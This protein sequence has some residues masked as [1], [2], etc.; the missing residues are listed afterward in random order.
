MGSPE[1]VPRPPRPGTPG[2]LGDAGE[3]ACTNSGAMT[4]T[5]G[6]SAV[7]LPMLSK[8]EEIEY[9][10]PTLEDGQSRG[11]H[12]S[13]LGWNHRNRNSGR[14]RCSA[15]QPHSAMTAATA[16]SIVV[17]YKAQSAASRLCDT[18]RTGIASKP[19][20]LHKPTA[21]LTL[22]FRC[23]GVEQQKGR[24]RR[25]GPD[26]Q[27]SEW[28]GEDLNLRP[29]GYEPDELPDCSTPRRIRRSYMSGPMSAMAPRHHGRND[30]RLPEAKPQR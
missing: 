13:L 30:C 20:E 1:I 21:L 18:T 12:G 11:P 2:K 14:L 5:T 15:I 9:S 10:V 29:S 24:F 3:K 17:A 8:A 19:T 6:R 22:S 27:L 28:R 26:L 4:V 16:A 23:H 25:T 7:P